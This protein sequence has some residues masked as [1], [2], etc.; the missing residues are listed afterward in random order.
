MVSFGLSKT[1]ADSLAKREIR[2]WLHTFVKNNSAEW[3]KTGVWGLEAQGQS[4]RKPGASPLKER[5]KLNHTLQVYVLP[6]CLE[7]AS[8]LDWVGEIEVQLERELMSAGD[9]ANMLTCVVKCGAVTQEELMIVMESG[10]ELLAE[11]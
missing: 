8:R 6:S 11:M 4:N 7:Q 1:S 3:R 2:S 5:V 9:F 10:E